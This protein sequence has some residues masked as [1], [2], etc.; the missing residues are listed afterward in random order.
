MAG[1]EVLGAVAGVAQL[2]ATVISI[3]KQLYEVSNA[4]SNAPSDIKDLAHDLE[5]FH[6]DLIFYADLVNARNAHYSKHFSRFTAKIIGRCAEICLKIDKVLKKLRSGSLW[7]KVKWIYKEKEIVKLLAKLRDLQ[8][9]LIGVLSVLISV[10][11]DYVLDALGLPTP[12]VFESAENEGLSPETIV[13][14]EETRRKLAG[15]TVGRDLPNRVQ[16]TS[17]QTNAFNSSFFSR[18][19]KTKELSMRS[20]PSTLGWTL[21]ENTLKQ[22]KFV[23]RATEEP[24]F[25]LLSKAVA[26]VN[27]PTIVYLDKH[28]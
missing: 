1:L 7:A 18:T 24:Y 4:L 3:S 9:S 10:K 13:D 12:S 21:V 17:E 20:T 8:L 5:M 2:A 23:A 14:I 16:N 25:E 27:T 6:D 19:A 28:Q 11:T 15:I 22:Y 26:T